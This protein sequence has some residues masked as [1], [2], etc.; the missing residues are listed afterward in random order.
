MKMYG[1]QKNRWQNYRLVK[2]R[3]GVR[4]KDILNDISDFIEK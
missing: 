4:K 2:R 1:P 3:E